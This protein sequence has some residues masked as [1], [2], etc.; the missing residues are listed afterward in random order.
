MIRN[1]LSAAIYVVLVMVAITSRIWPAPLS[2]DIGVALTVA[3]L[4]L[5]VSRTPAFQRN[6]GISL[7]IVGGIAAWAGGDLFGALYDGLEKAQLFMVMFFAVMWLRDPAITSP[8]LRNLRDAVVRQPPGRR[9]PIIWLTTHF[10]SSVLNFAALSLLSIMASEQTDRKLQRRLSIAIMLGF[11]AAAS[12]GPVYV[13]VA[14][15]LTAIPQVRWIDIAPLGLVLSA[16]TLA[17]GWTYDR[18]FLRLPPTGTERKG[19][20]RLPPG[21]SAAPRSSSCCCRYSCW[22]P[23]KSPGWRFRWR[24]A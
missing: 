7:G 22:A 3:F 2:R 13:S 5:E 15:I 19:G 10:L 6:V 18:I 1:Q 4:M 24:L 21:R 9:Y 11:A 20:R 8:S 16:F 23:T 17:I 12:W 14:V